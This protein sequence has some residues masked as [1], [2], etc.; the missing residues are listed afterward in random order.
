[1]WDNF[2]NSFSNNNL[3][4]FQRRRKPG[5]RT[6]SVSQQAHIKLKKLLGL[7]DV[8]LFYGQW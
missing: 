7:D 2:K 4:F 1:M 3:D 5:L 6:V 8:S